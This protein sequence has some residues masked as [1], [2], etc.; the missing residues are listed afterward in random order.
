MK[1]SMRYLFALLALFF[2]SAEAAAL[3]YSPSCS[4]CHKVIDYLEAKNLSIPQKNIQNP[5]YLKELSQL[6]GSSVPALEE[7]GRLI[8]GSDKI[9]K[10]LEVQK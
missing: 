4:H 6:G 9:I 3:Y 1:A 2:G 7:N 8:V 10:H 5:A